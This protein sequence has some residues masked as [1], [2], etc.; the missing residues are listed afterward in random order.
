[1]PII[2]AACCIACC[3]VGFNYYTNETTNYY[4]LVAAMSYS[5]MLVIGI[6]RWLTRKE[7]EQKIWNE[8]AEEWEHTNEIDQFMYM[9][10]IQW[11]ISLLIVGSVCLIAWAINS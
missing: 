7:P 2:I 3:F 4:L 10:L 1:V 8:L 11:I 9:N 6:W 5:P